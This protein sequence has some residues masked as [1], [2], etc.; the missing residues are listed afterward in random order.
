[1]NTIQL[2][3]QC[4]YEFSIDQD[5]VDRSLE[6]FLNLDLKFQSIGE[7]YDAEYSMMNHTN[8]GFI[9]CIYHEEL[10]IEIQKC[11]DMVAEKHFTN[12]KFA[13][14]DSWL[15]RSSFGQRSKQHCH[16]FSIF[17]GL[18]YMTDQEKAET[19]FYLP[20]PFYSKHGTLWKPLMKQ[21]PYMF[22]VKPVK[23]KLIIWDSS[24]EHK[25]GRMADKNKRYTL[26]FNTFPTGLISKGLTAQLKLNVVDVI[27]SSHKD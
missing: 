9:D 15:T 11:V 25:I 7:G 13:I 10:F 20:D 26:A 5:L 14:C 21:Q 6:Y 2:P 1:M 27:Q 4:L 23:G 12:T 24:I 19:I 16:A 22:T 17:S 8:D 3:T 18:L